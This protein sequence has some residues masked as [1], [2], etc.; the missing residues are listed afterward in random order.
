MDADKNNHQQHLLA[1]ALLLE[2]NKLIEA[3]NQ[4]VNAQ[5]GFDIASRRFAAL[6]DMFIERFVWWPFSEANFKLRGA[7]RFI[8]M[9]AGE[10]A[11]ALLKEA[12]RVLTL[13]EIVS[14]LNDGGFGAEEGGATARAVNAS[15][16][17]A[18]KVVKSEEGYR[19]DEN[20]L[21]F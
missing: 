14:A 4:L 10:A 3:N 19:Y 17:K 5:I 2:E 1:D 21:P 8:R 11:V 15:L 18:L 9:D 12:E 20:A 6:R 7:F 16:M 13:N